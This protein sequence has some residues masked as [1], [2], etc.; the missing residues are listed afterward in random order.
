MI[1][2]MT[3]TVTD[4]RGK[5][6]QRITEVIAALQNAHEPLTYDDIRIA[7]GAARGKD[8]VLRKGTPYDALLYILATLVEVGCVRRIE[9]A[10]GP[11]RPRMY[12]EW[13]L[14]GKSGVE[15]I[16]L[17]EAVNVS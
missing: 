13:C 4:I 3:G 1:P 16:S 6:E 17:Q 11:G 7:T 5:T 9:E 12:F 15:V 10:S 8:G 2:G 14:P